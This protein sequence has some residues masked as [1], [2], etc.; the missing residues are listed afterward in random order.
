[1]QDRNIEIIFNEHLSKKRHD[2]RYIVIDRDTGEVLDNAQGYGYKSRKNAHLG[3]AYKN[4]DKSKDSEKAAK[5]KHIQEWM[6]NHPEFSDDMDYAS[7][8]LAKELA[9][10]EDPSGDINVNLVKSILKHH[11]LEID[12]TPTELLREWKEG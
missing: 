1:M 12:F 9:C 8:N 4:R 7:F 10:G 2:E 11:G 3:W 5:R 6:K